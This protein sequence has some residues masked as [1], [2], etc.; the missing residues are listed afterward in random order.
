MTV[1]ML[2]RSSGKLGTLVNKDLKPAS[3]PK[4]KTVEFSVD[5]TNE[6]AKTAWNAGSRIGQS[7]FYQVVSA[8]TAMKT[9]KNRGENPP[10]LW[11]SVPANQRRKGSVG[12]LVSNQ[13]S[14]LFYRCTQSDLIDI[15]TGVA[16]INTQLKAQIK[17]N[18][19]LRYATLLSALRFMPLS[20]YE[21]MVDLASKGKTSSFG[22]SDLGDFKE[23]ISHFQGAS[24]LGY[25][26]LP[27]CS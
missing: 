4:F 5:E 7:V 13:L 14:F 23:P 17:A 8:I 9:L 18:I 6:I 12:H 3:L 21:A 27:S 25:K 2:K 26:T 11:F 1:Y 24:V 10:Y 19:A 22:F 16:S 15:K 20:I